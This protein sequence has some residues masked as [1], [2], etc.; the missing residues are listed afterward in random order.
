[1]ARVERV[2][3][4]AG[5]ALVDLHRGLSHREVVRREGGQLHRVLQQTRSG[6]KAGTWQVRSTRIVLADRVEDTVVVEAGA[7]DDLKKLVGDRELHVPPR[8]RE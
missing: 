5:Q 6:G 1:M 3:N 2:D 8:V 4:V 7:V